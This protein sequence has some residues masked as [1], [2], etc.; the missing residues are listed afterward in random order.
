MKLP[1]L[2][3]RRAITAVCILI[4][5]GLITG[6][7]L[8]YRHDQTV[9]AQAAAAEEAKKQQVINEKAQICYQQKQKERAD[10]LGKV[11]YDQLYDG[12]SCYTQ[13]AQ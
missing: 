4:A 1:K 5:T 12:N 10:M 13:A 7:V 9:R 3:K 6:G 2:T 11:T 8:W